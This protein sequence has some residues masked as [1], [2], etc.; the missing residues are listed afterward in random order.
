MYFNEFIFLPPFKASGLLFFF[1]LRQN[2]PA[3]LSGFRRVGFGEFRVDTPQ[4][5]NQLVSLPIRTHNGAVN[6]DHGKIK[7]KK[8]GFLNPA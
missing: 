3:I 8:A 1:C 6:G 4:L 5:T 2:N 7:T